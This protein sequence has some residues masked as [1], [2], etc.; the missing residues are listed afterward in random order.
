MEFGPRYARS[1]LKFADV[2]RILQNQN[3]NGA[4]LWSSFG[5]RDFLCAMGRKFDYRAERVTA[6][7]MI[8]DEDRREAVEG[9]LSR[10]LELYM[11]RW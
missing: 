10:C 3:S 9:D 1:A 4:L 8:D 5:D 6:K 7:E 2:A 11:K